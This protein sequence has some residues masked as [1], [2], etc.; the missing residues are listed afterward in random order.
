MKNYLWRRLGGTPPP[1]S[2]VALGSTLLEYLAAVVALQYT[3][4]HKKT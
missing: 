4:N 2:P 3:L 1:N